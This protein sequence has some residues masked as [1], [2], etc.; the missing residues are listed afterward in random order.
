MVEV[1]VHRGDD[2]TD[3]VVLN[4]DE[5]LRQ[6]RDVVVVHDGD[7]SH[8]VFAAVPGFGSELGSNEVS[9]GFGAVVEEGV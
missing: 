4:G 1:N 8:D 5:L 3:A 6:T 7:G 2:M 9:N